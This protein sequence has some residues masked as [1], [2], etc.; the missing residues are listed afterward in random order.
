MNVTSIGIG[1]TNHVFT[2]YWIVTKSPS[3]AQA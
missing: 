2:W 3:T 1:N